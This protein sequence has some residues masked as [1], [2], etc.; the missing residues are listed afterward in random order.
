[1]GTLS[2]PRKVSVLGST[3]SIGVSTLDLFSQAGVEVE[4]VGLA[5]GRN[6]A[7]LAEQALQWRPQVAVIEDEALLPELRERLK[8]SGIA[9]AAGAQA[10]TDVAS[11][12]AQW[13]MSAIVGFAGL[14]PTLA[15]AKAGAVI[16]LA[17]KESLVCAGPSLLRTAKLAGGAVVPVDSEH[18][19]IFQVLDP[20][21]AAHVSRLILTSSGGPFRNATREEMAAATL[22]QALA[23]PNFSMGAKIS[24]DSA[25]MMN[26]GLE[27]IEAA[28]LFS[29]PP[30]RIEVL[31]H[32]QQIIHSLVEYADGSTLAQLGPPDMRPPIACGFAWPDRLPWPAPKLDLVTAGPLTFQH[33]DPQKFPAL[34]IAKQALAT[35]GQAPAAMNAANERAVSAF[36]DRRI[37][38]LDIPNVVAETLERM[39]R[40]QTFS[41]ANDAVESARETDAAARRMAD[42]VVTGLFAA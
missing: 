1:M 12:D 27:V 17:N 4:V 20:L 42:E 2:L 14:A 5:A 41:T 31:V 29:M 28:Y 30:E 40:S 15:A 25:T 39:D 16:A 22:E 36:L 8:G 3:G 11:A 35:G 7:R 38:F 6:V 26:K 19:A 37:G 24:I 32:P 18:S 23:H 33:P 9:A 10:V 21:A 34:S 13:V